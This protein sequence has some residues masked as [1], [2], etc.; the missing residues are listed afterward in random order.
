M[1]FRHVVM[2]KWEDH[3][4]DDHVEQVRAGLSALPPVI[5]VIRSYVH[6]TDVGVSEGT[7]DYVVVADFDDVADFHTYRDHPQHVQLIEELIKGHVADRAAIQYET[8]P[9]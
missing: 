9:G 6:G 1:P 4:D 8:G 5:D 3:V 7:Y 2:F